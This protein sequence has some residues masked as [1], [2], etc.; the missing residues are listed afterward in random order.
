[1]P[2]QSE[3]FDL[4][5]HR[6]CRGLMPENSIP[7][8][9]KAL[10]SGV[11]TLELDVVVS[12]DRQV[13]V[14]HDPYISAVFCLTPDGQPVDKKIQAQLN[15]Y[16][17]TYEQIRQYDCGSRNHAAYPEQQK[18]KTVKPLLR[19]VITQMEAYRVE[20]NLPAFSYNIEIKSEPDQY[21]ISQPEPAE[22]SE[23][24][25]RVVSEQLPPERV[26]MQSFDFN[27][28]KYWK[29]RIDQGHYRKVRLSALVLDL[30]SVDSH[31]KRLGFTPDIYSPY[32]RLLGKGTIR[33]LHEKGMKVIP[34]TVNDP[35]RMKRLRDW[36]VDGLITDYPDRAKYL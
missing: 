20:K 12:K 6:G 4:Q 3:P 19:E 32:H 28:L 7:A 35:G 15:L 16:R 22:F 8:F 31:L 26:I 27:V 25:Y 23:L 13:V 9:L 2:Y 14:S 10:D 18:L 24:V 29:E 17:M 34:W 33:H 11:T 21:G 30:K 1:M 36:G 5:G